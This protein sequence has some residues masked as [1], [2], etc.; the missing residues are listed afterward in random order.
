MLSVSDYKPFLGLLHIPQSIKGPGAKRRRGDGNMHYVEEMVR[1]EGEW[2]IWE[3]D[4]EV[5]GVSAIP[6]T[7]RP[8]SSANVTFATALLSEP[9][10]LR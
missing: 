4:G 7:T 9:V 10:P 5:E 8:S 2:S 6:T 1:D 3:V